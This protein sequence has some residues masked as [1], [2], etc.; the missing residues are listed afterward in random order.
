LVFDEDGNYVGTYSGPWPTFTMIPVESDKF[1]AVRQ[2]FPHNT[3]EVV[4]K[5][6]CFILNGTTACTK[7]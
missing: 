1:V 5:E 7:E 4:F 2:E 3:A 6:N